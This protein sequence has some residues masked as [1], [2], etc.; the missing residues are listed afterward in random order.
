MLNL[1]LNT[2]RYGQTLLHASIEIGLVWFYGISTIVDYIIPI[3]FLCLKA[4]LF[5][6][7]QFN[8]NTPFSSISPIDRTLSDA[9]KVDMR[10]IAIK[11]YFALPKV[12]ALLEP[13]HWIVSVS[14]KGHL[15]A[16]SYSSDEVQSLY[17]AATVDSARKLEFFF[18]LI[19]SL[20]KE[21][22]LNISDRAYILKLVFETH[23][24]TFTFSLVGS[25]DNKRKTENHQ[26]LLTLPPWYANWDRYTLFLHVWFI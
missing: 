14:Y 1:I 5:P 15:L 17:S 19:I 8:I 25:P 4:V 18:L 24:L 22:V 10:E 7:V 26:T 3:P 2:F 12:P 20:W 6:T 16:E 23:Q 9:T 13:H 21:I 11:G